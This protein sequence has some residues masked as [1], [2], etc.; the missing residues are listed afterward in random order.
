LFFALL[1]EVID[2]SGVLVLGDAIADRAGIA[3]HLEV[4]AE[5]P[6]QLLTRRLGQ[7]EDSLVGGLDLLGRERL[8]GDI[9]VSRWSGLLPRVRRGLSRI[10]GNRHIC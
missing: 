5:G 1:K 7:G 10:G 6:G 2:E 8:Q 9:E 3:R 4:L